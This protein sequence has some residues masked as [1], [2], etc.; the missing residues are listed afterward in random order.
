MYKL[1]NSCSYR[2]IVKTTTYYETH[3]CV[4]SNHK[5]KFILH[6]ALMVERC[7]R[8]FENMTNWGQVIG[9]V[10]TEIRQESRNFHIKE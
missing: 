6:R 8:I 4:W 7:E 3:K 5:C 10:K 9:I 2:C 1:G